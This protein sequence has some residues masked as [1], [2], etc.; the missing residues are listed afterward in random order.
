MDSPIVVSLVISGIGMTLLF[1]ALLLFYF[2]LILLAK[3]V[4]EKRSPEEPVGVTESAAIHEV[5]AR[6]RAAILGVALARAS[7]QAGVAPI[8]SALPG[9]SSDPGRGSPWWDL[10][11]TQ[12]LLRVRPSRRNR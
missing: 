8:A 11:H 5:G 4:R 6:E 9:D 7:V 12:R 3:V 2:L 1:L 10:H